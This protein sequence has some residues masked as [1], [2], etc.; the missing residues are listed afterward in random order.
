MRVLV[1]FNHKGGTLPQHKPREEL[2]LVKAAF[3]GS[4]GQCGHYG[5][6]RQ[7]HPA[8]RLPLGTFNHFA[9]D[10]DIPLA[11]DEA[12]RVVTNGYTAT[13]DLGE[14]NGPPHGDQA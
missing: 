2:A 12:T 1:V 5:H 3:D 7:G 9:K 4:G 10:L 11:L 13:V 6:A 8:W 14:V